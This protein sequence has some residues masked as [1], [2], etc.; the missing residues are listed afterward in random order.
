MRVRRK[1]DGLDRDSFD[2]A[3]R[4]FDH[5]HARQLV[6]DRAWRELAGYLAG[7][8]DGDTEAAILRGNRAR[9]LS[10]IESL[11]WEQLDQLG[12]EP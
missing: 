12:S 8:V 3:L 2:D 11:A 5:R 10:A 6:E 1:S 7:L 9:A 4:A